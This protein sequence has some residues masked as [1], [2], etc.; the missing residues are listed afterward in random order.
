MLRSHYGRLT[1]NLILSFIAMYLVM[2]AMIDG[3]D[4]F[5]NNIN[6]TLLPSAPPQAASESVAAASSKLDL[7]VMSVFLSCSI[8]RHIWSRP[9]VRTPPSQP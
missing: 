3:I 9:W 7:V 8:Q 1:I 4:D 2:F 6:M 5:Y